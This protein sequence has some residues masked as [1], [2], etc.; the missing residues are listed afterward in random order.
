MLNLFLFLGFIISFVMLFKTGNGTLEIL[1]RK[2]CIV[3]KIDTL[4][5]I[6]YSAVGFLGDQWQLSQKVESLW[7]GPNVFYFCLLP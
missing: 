3:I 1:P 5:L 4:I 7:L 2:S 6:L